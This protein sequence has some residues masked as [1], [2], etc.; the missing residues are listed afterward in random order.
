MLWIGRRPTNCCRSVYLRRFSR[1]GTCDSSCPAPRPHV[2][3]GDGAALDTYGLRSVTKVDFKIDVVIS[4]LIITR[5]FETRNATESSCA[6]RERKGGTDEGGLLVTR[7]AGG[8]AAD[9]EPESPESD[10]PAERRER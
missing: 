5:S 6:E 1:S 8:A 10:R 7:H 4:S 9:R 2:W 3:R